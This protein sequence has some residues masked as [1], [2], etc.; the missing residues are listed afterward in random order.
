MLFLDTDQTHVTLTVGHNLH[1]FLST[2]NYL[3]MIDKT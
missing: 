2:P 3:F 1:V